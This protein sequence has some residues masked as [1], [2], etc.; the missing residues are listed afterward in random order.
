MLLHDHQGPSRA[1][2]DGQTLQPH[3]EGGKS[4]PDGGD[5]CTHSEGTEGLPETGC[6]G[7]IP[8]VLPD[9]DNALL[10]DL[11]LLPSIYFHHST[12]FLSVLLHA[13]STLAP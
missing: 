9:H 6:I 5:L 2:F 10:S 1:N 4:P 11:F 7:F 13:C 12:T 8:A 3:V